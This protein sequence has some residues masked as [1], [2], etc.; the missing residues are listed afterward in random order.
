MAR[1]SSGNGSEEAWGAL[2]ASQ[3]QV[4]QQL[5]SLSRQPFV[6]FPFPCP[7]LFGGGGGTHGAKGTVKFLNMFHSLSKLCNV[8]AADFSCSLIDP[9]PWLQWKLAVARQ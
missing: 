7:F 9:I 1:A 8:D 4:S 6:S 3:Q 2:R 5:Q